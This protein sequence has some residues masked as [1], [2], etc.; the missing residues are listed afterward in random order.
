MKASRAA[1]RMAQSL[2]GLLTAEEAR[3]AQD[4]RTEALLKQVLEQQQTILSAV[5]QLAGSKMDVDE[6]PS[7]S[8]RKASSE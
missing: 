6:K 2:E 7:V 8:K 4:K 5:M 1:A 3:Q